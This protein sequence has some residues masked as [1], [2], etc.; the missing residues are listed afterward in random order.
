MKTRLDETNKMRKLMGLSLITEQETGCD[1]PAGRCVGEVFESDICTEGVDYNPVIVN[2]VENISYD[3]GCFKQYSDWDEENVKDYLEGV[4]NNEKDDFM[5]LLYC[6]M[7]GAPD[8]VFS[9]MKNTDN[10]V[11]ILIGELSPS[12]QILDDTDWDSVK[13]K[14]NIK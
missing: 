13:T 6:Y 8:S 14:Y 2:A 12:W 4:P 9:N 11:E 1:T 7:K 3:C 10:P 5:D